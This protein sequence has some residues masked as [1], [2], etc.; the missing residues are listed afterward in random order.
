MSLLDFGSVKQVNAATNEVA[1]RPAAWRRLLAAAIDCVLPLPFLA[2]FFSEWTL[3]VLAYHLLCD[4]SVSRRSAGKWICRLRV[5][6]NDT[7]GRCAWWQAA[8]RRIGVAA[9]QAA[10]CLW[11]FIPLA[12]VYELCAAACVLLDARGRRP[13]DFL[14]GTRVVTEKTFRNIK[15]VKHA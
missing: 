15:E 13:E 7:A 14:A 10:W 9:T 4:C 2:W 3:V 12:L 11:Q 5:I 8:T 6:A 1:R